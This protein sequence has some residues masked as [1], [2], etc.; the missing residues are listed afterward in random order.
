MVSYR[1]ELIE[2]KAKEQLIR[3]AEEDFT[4]SSSDLK[5]MKETR[6]LITDRIHNRAA[7]NR[8]RTIRSLEIDLPRS[9][10]GR[11]IYSGGTR[12]VRKNGPTNLEFIHTFANGEQLPFLSKGW[13][14]FQKKT[15]QGEIRYYRIIFQDAVELNRT[16]R[17]RSKSMRE[18]IAAIQKEIDGVSAKMETMR[19]GSSERK[20]ENQ[21][22]IELKRKLERINRKK[23]LYI[24]PS[25]TQFKYNME[26]QL[27]RMSCDFEEISASGI[28]LP[29]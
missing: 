25:P 28:P 23:E 3:E 1:F 13:S 20:E 5:F 10:Y 19:R 21:K 8:S 6:A 9:L 11:F 24:A 2:E 4:Y 18:D 12:T 14:K 7:R 16:K 26:K 22:K 27:L 17:L 29:Y 15:K